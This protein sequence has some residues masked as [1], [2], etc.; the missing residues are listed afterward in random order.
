M[1]DRYDS[2]IRSSR[3]CDWLPRAGACRVGRLLWPI[4][5]PGGEIERV[6]DPFAYAAE[7]D[8]EAYLGLWEAS[9]VEF[10][11]MQLVQCIAIPRNRARL[12]PTLTS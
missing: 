12:G 5:E 3:L 4:P 1:G 9:A 10:P 8:G 2:Q 7:R 11:A 6:G